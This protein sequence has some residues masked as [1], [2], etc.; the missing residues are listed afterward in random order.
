MTT[1]AIAPRSA[2]IEPTPHL[3]SVGI[4]CG[5]GGCVPA[6]TGVSVG[7]GVDGGGGG[8]LSSAGVLPPVVSTCAATCVSPGGSVAWTVTSHSTVAVPPAARSPSAT[9]TVAS[10]APLP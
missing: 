9:A 5:G 1:A 2:I 3:P 6:V 4:A 7:P 10:P 8:P